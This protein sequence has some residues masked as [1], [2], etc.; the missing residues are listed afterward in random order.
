MGGSGCAGQAGRFCWWVGKQQHHRAS[1]TNSGLVNASSAPPTGPMLTRMPS[2]F[3]CCRHPGCPADQLRSAGLE[4]RLAPVPGPGRGARPHHAPGRHHAA[5][6]S[7]LPH[8]AVGVGR[9]PGW[10]V[11]RGSSGCCTLV[12]RAGV[13]GMRGMAA[14][15]RCRQLPAAVGRSCGASLTCPAL[16]RH[17]P[18]PTAPS[19]LLA[20]PA[21]V[22]AP[23][24]C[25]GH[26]EKGRHVLE[27]LRGTTNVHAG[28][29]CCC[30]CLCCLV[31]TAAACAAGAARRAAGCGAVAG[32]S[33]RRTASHNWAHPSHP[34]NPL[35][36]PARLPVCMPLPACLPACLPFLPASACRVQRHPGGLCQRRQYPHARRERRCRC[37]QLLPRLPLLPAPAADVPAARDLSACCSS[38]A[39]PCPCHTRVQVPCCPPLVAELESDVHPALLPHAGGHRA[40]RH[41]AAVDGH[42]CGKWGWVGVEQVPVGGSSKTQIQNKL[43]ITNISPLSAPRQIIFYMPAIPATH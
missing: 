12:A 34:P 14:A 35:N 39:L 26:L 5:R 42:Q 28:E 2:F 17:L 21:C 38:C 27:R 32:G 43:L 33:T 8:R 9:A 13:T 1:F 3:L 7:Q 10:T 31:S 30:C 20:P 23:P 4:P 37:Q 41:P 29:R 16:L 36:L 24:A 22:L 19:A 25:S 40:H 6:V 11:G 15:S 18:C